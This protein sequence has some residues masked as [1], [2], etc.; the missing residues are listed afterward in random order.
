MAGTVAWAWAT[1]DAMDGNYTTVSTAS[2]ATTSYT[3]VAADEGKYLRATA[4]YNDG[5]KTGNTEMAV[6]ES[7]VSTDAPDERPQAVQD[8]D[9][10]GDPGIQID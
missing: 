4:T 9:R 5:F 3:P 7:A 2:A 10:D 1:A 8:Y 6:G